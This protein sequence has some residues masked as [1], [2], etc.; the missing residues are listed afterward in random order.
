MRLAL[1]ALL[2]TGC[3]T[4]TGATGAKREVLSDALKAQPFPMPVGEAADRLRQQTRIRPECRWTLEGT[5]RCNA[6]VGGICLDLVD[7]A[8]MTRV[9]L[10][11]PLLERDATAVWM[12]LDP[13]TY[14]QLTPELPTLVNEKLVEQE[15]R[16][17]GR[18]GVLGGIFSSLLSDSLGSTGVGGRIGVRRWFDA[19]L[20]AQAAV[21]YAWRG[22]HEFHARVGVEVTRWT[23]GR[24]WGALGAPGASVTMFIGPAVRTALPIVSIR[25]GVGLL[26]TDFRG[27]PIFAEFSADTQLLGESSR[28]VGGFT[29]GIGL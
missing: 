21:Q 10:S 5:Q 26:L 28:V 2:L 1:L 25:T 19:H 13:E 12:A 24:F 27:P 8:A 4:F 14:A 7:E 22:E 3:A 9:Q 6:C 16:A 20:G 15:Q 18:W 17:Q 11:E 29:V 23:E